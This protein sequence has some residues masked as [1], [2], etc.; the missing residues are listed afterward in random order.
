[1]MTRWVILL[2]LLLGMPN[3]SAL[4]SPAELPG[5]QLVDLARVDLATIAARDAQLSREGAA[6]RVASGHTQL[7]PGITFSA[8]LEPWDLSRFAL[9]T[10]AVK[11][12]GNEELNLCCR[13]DTPGGNGVNQS[14][15]AA[16]PLRPGETGELRVALPR[17]RSNIV[18]QPGKMLFGMR[19]YPA[20]FG[21]EVVDPADL[22]TAMF[23]PRSVSAV[24]VFVNH[25][26]ADGAFEIS[27]VHA[28]G[29]AMPPRLSAD[30]LFPLID[31]YG[32]YIHRDWPG[33]TH[34][35]AELLAF[36]AQ[37]T[38]DL[39]D[40]PGPPDWDRFGGWSAGPTLDKTGFFRTEK[41]H[42]KWWL[43][44]PEGKPFF[45]NGID[46]IGNLGQTGIENRDNWFADFP[47]GQI[48]FREFLSSAFSLKGDY[49]GQNVQTFSFAAANLK[50][51]FGD[52]WRT[53]SGELAQQRLRS[54]GLNTLGNWSSPDICYLHKTPYVMALSAGRL[55]PIAGSYG[56]WGKFV[57]PFDPQ[58][59]VQLTHNIAAQ[60]ARAINDPWC[61]GFFV[62][63]ELSW[64]TWSRDQTSLAVATLR[65]PPDQPA[66]LA[67]VA[68]LKTKYG[69]IAALNGGWGTS[70]ASW[71]ALLAWQDAP[72]TPLADP[73]LAAFYSRI[74]EQYFS[75][76]RTA[77]KTAAPHQLYLGCRF[78]SNCPR[79]R[80]A[81]AKYCDVVSFNFYTTSEAA[82]KLP[83]GDVPV[84][85]GEFHFG[86]LDRGLFHPG[87]VPVASQ[88]ARA[89]AYRRFVGGVLSN[90]CLVGCH[91]F[92]YQDEPTTGRVYDGENYQIGFVDVVNN[93]YPETIQACRDVG[94]SMYATRMGQR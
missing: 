51:R 2:G 53:A 73:D 23:D 31:A 20:E 68:D 41:Y 83:E 12:V 65:S 38:R 3:L 62:G 30:Q 10:V 28:E 69:D 39:H 29:A 52:D 4:A 26:T 43:V 86:A 67:F 82:F 81:A 59:A 42:G 32:Q 89:D 66:K 8:P 18:P 6:L 74:A 54:W 64:A 11:N 46:C 50:R 34:S 93:P 61:I 35:P 92:Q 88:Q 5:L 49:A 85:I 76:V 58:F 75:V 1:M 90:P 57:D 27:G 9:L 44:D 40:H 14:V 17:P 55:R 72:A 80:A 33:K 22:P 37:E 91:W 36:A 56:Y 24:L 7:Y 13:A 78:A 15:T 47:G 77:L 70:Y 48:A 25:P 21:T 60:G 45:S 19:G 16:L 79:A 71:D 84:L 87:L 63:N 94:Y